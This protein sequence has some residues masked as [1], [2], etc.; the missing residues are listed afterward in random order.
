[1]EALKKRMEAEQAQAAKDDKELAK[2]IADAA[3]GKPG[4]K[5]CECEGKPSL[6]EKPV[7]KTHVM[8]EE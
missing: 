8:I 3:A 6:H 7:D 1:M 5:D 2:K 4:E